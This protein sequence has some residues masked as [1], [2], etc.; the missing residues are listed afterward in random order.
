M[1]IHELADDVHPSN[2]YVVKPAL[3]AELRLQ[4]AGFG[5]HK[6][7]RKRVRVSAKQRIGQADVAPEEIQQMQAD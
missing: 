7:P 3:I 4:L 2:V 5:V 6:V 1:Q